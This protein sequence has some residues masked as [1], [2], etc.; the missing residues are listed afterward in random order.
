[1]GGI[2]DAEK[3]RKERNNRIRVLLNTDVGKEL[4]ADLMSKSSFLTTAG[5]KNLEFREGQRDI[6]LYL[7]KISKLSAEN[8]VDLNRINDEYVKKNSNDDKKLTTY[9]KMMQEV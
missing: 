3:E 4:L 8:L 1:M 5:P 2:V 7:F 9:Q 6:F